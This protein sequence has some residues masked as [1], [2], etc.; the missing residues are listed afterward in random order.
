[1]GGYAS[2]PSHRGISG[3]CALRPSAATYWPTC[4]CERPA[5]PPRSPTAEPG[6]P[7]ERG[8]RRRRR[9]KEQ[10]AVEPAGTLIIDVFDAGRVTQTAHR[11]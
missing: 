3:S 10:R 11:T 1:M 9:A 7:H 2:L 4:P 6:P 5:Q 8:A